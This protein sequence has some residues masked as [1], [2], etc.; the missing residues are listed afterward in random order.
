M[1][2]ISNIRYERAHN[3]LKKAGQGAQVSDIAMEWG[4]YQLGRFSQEYKKRYG[5]S[6]SVTLKNR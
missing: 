5:E 1:N 4:F 2:H 3:A 6:P